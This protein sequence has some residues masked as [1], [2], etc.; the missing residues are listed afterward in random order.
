MRKLSFSGPASS[1]KLG[2]QQLQCGALTSIPGN[3]VPWKSPVTEEGRSLPPFQ[4]DG[5]GPH[6]PTED[7]GLPGSQH[8]WNQPNT[9][10]VPGASGN[11]TRPRGMPR[12]TEQYV[13][14]RPR[15][16]EAHRPRGLGPRPGM[17]LK[18][19]RKLRRVPRERDMIFPSPR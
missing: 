10:W 9:M 8:A 12:T 7:A 17:V 18:W 4:V 2:K 19:F 16:P 14:S 6:V 1:P 11:H 5:E 3:S 13:G 15:G